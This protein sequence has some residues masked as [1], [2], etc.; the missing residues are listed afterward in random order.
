MKSQLTIADARR[1][2]MEGQEALSQVESNGMRIDTAYLD[3]MII[4]SADKISQMEVDLK[5]DEVWQQWKKKYGEDANLDSGEQ[6]GNILFNVMG[7]ECKAKT[8]TGRPKTDA[9]AL[10]Q[11]DFPFVRKYLK[12]GKLRRTRTNNL[13]GIRNETVNGILHPVFS[14]NLVKSYRSSSSLPNAQNFPIRD[15]FLARL[16]RQAFIP[17]DGHVLLEVD[18]ASAEVRVSACYHN[19]PRMVEY[20]HKNH[21]YHKEL[22]M[23]CFKLP[24]DQVTKNVRGTAKANFVFA[25]FYGDWYINICQN[26][27]NAIAKDRLSRVDGVGLYD[28][29]A[30]QGITELGGLEK[31]PVPGTFEAHIK[32][33]Y[34]DFWNVR[35]PVYSKWKEDWWQAYLK[36]GYCQSLT[37]FIFKGIYRRNEIINYPVQSGSFHCLLWSLIQINNWLNEKKMK[38]MIIGQIHDSIILDVYLKELDDVL[39]KCYQTMTRDIR[40]TWEW[41]TVPLEIEGAVSEKNWYEKKTVGMGV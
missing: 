29:L 6:L 3:R 9:D 34:D 40:Q 41:I 2:F 21:D 17:R 16:V 23:Q 13:I 25:S 14:L 26:L 4:E 11:V 27:W 22:A 28:H 19:D 12:Y 33:V 7:V 18:M 10:E 31:I 30:E 36:N 20:I 38:S 15:D 8:A 32:S 37:G 5:K 24:A 1:L 35:F 39:S